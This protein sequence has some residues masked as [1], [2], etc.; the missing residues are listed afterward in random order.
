MH[1]RNVLRQ[2]LRTR[3]SGRAGG[4]FED[5]VLE[6]KNVDDLCEAF[7]KFA[8]SN[9]ATANDALWAGFDPWLRVR[10]IQV[11]LPSYRNSSI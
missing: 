5:H 9:G 4:A 2:S 3:E 10:K 8:K 1:L 6:V 7:G 11:F